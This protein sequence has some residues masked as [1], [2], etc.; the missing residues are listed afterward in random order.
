MKVNGMLAFVFFTLLLGFIFL[1]FHFFAAASK[2]ASAAIWQTIAAVDLI[3][4]A[5]SAWYVMAHN[6]FADLWG[7][8]IL[9]VGKAWIK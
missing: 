6:I 5:L 3:I 9:P 1:D 7:R 8:D 4:C 2:S